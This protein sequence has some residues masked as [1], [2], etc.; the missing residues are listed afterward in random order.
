MIEI[1][2]SS[3]K[4]ALNDYGFVFTIDYISEGPSA[5][6]RTLQ[7]IIS[8]Q[9]ETNFTDSYHIN[10]AI[11]DLLGSINDSISRRD[12]A[13]LH[14]Y[15]GHFLQL[16]GINCTCEEKKKEFFQNAIYEYKEI[17][18]ANNIIGEAKYYAQWQ[19][20]VLQEWLSTPWVVVQQ[21]L[22]NS[23]KFAP[24]RAEA[25]KHL[26]LHYKNS[27]EW[28]VAYLFSKYSVN[29]FYGEPPLQDSWLP[30]IQFYN[31]R[32]L[33][34]HVSICLHLFRQD[35]A[36]EVFTELLTCTRRHPE[37]FSQ[38]QIEMIMNNKIA[39]QL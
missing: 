38:Q 32:I 17:P 2:S 11:L 35:E 6:E 1:T 7:R 28:A 24:Y 16:A 12:T 18:K 20:A 3:T 31:W 19:I 30:D 14:L 21:S 29:N 8:Q 10:L 37:F 5:I 26:I 36:K 34:Y 33:D 4:A 27:K 39:L 13:V 22:L 9:F 23:G 15:K 25:I